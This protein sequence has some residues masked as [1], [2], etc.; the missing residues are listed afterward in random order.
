MMS[1]NFEYLSFMKLLGMTLVRS[2]SLFSGFINSLHCSMLN[3]KPLK[4]FYCPLG[5]P[6]AV[7][8]TSS[9]MERLSIPTLVVVPLKFK[10]N[11]LET[12]T[13][14]PCNFSQKCKQHVL[15]KTSTTIGYS[16][17]KFIFAGSYLK[18]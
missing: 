8:I 18:H 1:R 2:I 10:A 9:V 14:Q 15:L 6:V 13:W 12:C 11:S 3:L 17:I 4:H 7:A 5:I 16:L